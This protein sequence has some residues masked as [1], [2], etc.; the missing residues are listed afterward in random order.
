MTDIN[1]LFQQPKIEVILCAA[2]T[3]QLAINDF[4]KEHDYNKIIESV[5]KIVIK[6]RSV[7]NANLLTI[8]NR[9][10][11]TVSNDTRGTLRFS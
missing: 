11:P 7:E 10:K 3:L 8:N 1:E 5:K 2:H 6:L 9:I 4:F